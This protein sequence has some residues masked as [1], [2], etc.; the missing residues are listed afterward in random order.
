MGGVQRSVEAE[1][2]DAGGGVECAGAADE[3]DGEA[4]CRMHGQE[5][6]EQIGGGERIEGG[7]IEAEVEAIDGVSAGAQP[8]GGRG[9]AERLVAHIVG[10]NKED[11]HRRGADPIMTSGCTAEGRG[12]S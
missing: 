10:G 7:G 5:K 11:T 9:E 6:S 1:A 8:G 2:G 12:A 3:G 4:G